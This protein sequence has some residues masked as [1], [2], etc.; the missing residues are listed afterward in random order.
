MSTISSLLEQSLDLI[1]ESD[2]KQSNTESNPPTAS[3]SSI[4]LAEKRQKQQKAATY[5]HL[6]DFVPISSVKT[7]PP[8]HFLNQI[9]SSTTEAPTY[10]KSSIATVSKGGKKAIKAASTLTLVSKAKSNKMKK[11]TDYQDKFSSKQQK[12]THDPLAHLKK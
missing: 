6:P 7:A 8:N 10:W 4:L 9:A 1:N 2:T 5:E 11:G 12:R 3:A